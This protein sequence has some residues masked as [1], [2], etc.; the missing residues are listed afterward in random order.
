MA[1]PFELMTSRVTSRVMSL[2]PPIFKKLDC[3]LLGVRL[4]STKVSF[5]GMKP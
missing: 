5:R 3:E 1:Q 4:E 2:R